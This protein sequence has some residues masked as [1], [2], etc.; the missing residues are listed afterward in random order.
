V[1][2]FPDCA[3]AAIGDPRL[4][5][6]G[7]W[8]EYAQDHGL[9]FLRVRRS[10]L[11]MIYGRA[12]CDGLPVEMGYRG[13][14]AVGARLEFTDDVAE[15]AATH[16]GDWHTLGDIRIGSSG[17]VAVDKRRPADDRREHRLALPAGWYAAQIFE[18]GRDHLGIRLIT[19]ET[20]SP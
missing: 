19:L 7:A 15:L 18:H 10:G 6:D 17:A 13:S 20:A 1:G 11:G 16:S 12:E 5:D 9:P 8:L 2:F 4:L 3:F 14:D